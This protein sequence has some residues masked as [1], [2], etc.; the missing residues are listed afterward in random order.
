MID[1]ARNIRYVE[2][3]KIQQPAM[4]WLCKANPT[5]GR[6][7]LQSLP[8]RWKSTLKLPKPTGYT[9][10]VKMLEETDNFLNQL[11]VLFVHEFCIDNHW[12]TEK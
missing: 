4:T 10:P 7:D 8:Q 2:D 9:K 11:T 5:S 3:T 6:F 1:T 12:K